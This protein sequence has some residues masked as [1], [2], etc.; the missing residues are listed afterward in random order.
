MNDEIMLTKKQVELTSKQAGT[1]A[2]TKDGEQ[3]LI[4]LTEWIDFLT[5]KLEEAK[6]QMAED[7]I[8]NGEDNILGSTL[9]VAV[10]KTG[11]KYDGSNPEFIKQVS[12]PRIDEKKV[13]EY[14]AK[15]G[16][17]P[18]GISEQLQKVSASIYVKKDKK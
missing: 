12:Y 1:F 14:K 16:M 3:Y 8:K 10:R 2:V 6:E 13:D 15:E 11:K 4:Q 17:L 18:E 9:R 7:A 5:A